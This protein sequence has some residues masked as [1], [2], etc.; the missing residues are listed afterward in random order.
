MTNATDLTALTGLADS[1]AGGTGDINHAT[2]NSNPTSTV[3]QFSSEVDEDG[4]S[5]QPPKE[6]AWDENKETGRLAP[7]Y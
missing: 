4:Y 3:G 2:K 6:V 1:T 7:L 5:I